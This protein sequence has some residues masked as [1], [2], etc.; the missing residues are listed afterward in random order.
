[1]ALVRGSF[2]NL[3][4]FK[5]TLLGKKIAKFKKTVIRREYS[6]LMSVHAKIT[7]KLQSKFEPIHLDIV[8]ESY[9]HNVPNGSETHFKV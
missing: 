9:K 7:E 6:S 8:N 5:G 1:M 3:T 4:N 2:S